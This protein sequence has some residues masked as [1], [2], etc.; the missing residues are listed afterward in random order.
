MDTVFSIFAGL[1]ILFVG[2]G[3]LLIGV[4][5]MKSAENQNGRDRA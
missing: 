1:G 3:V 5:S 2:L 4:G